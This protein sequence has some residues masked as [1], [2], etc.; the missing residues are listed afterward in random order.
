MFLKQRF[1]RKVKSSSSNRRTSSNNRSS[2][3]DNS[4]LEG[5]Q[6]CVWVHWFFLVC[7]QI[8]LQNKSHFILIDA[9]L[10]HLV[11]KLQDCQSHEIFS[12]WDLNSTVWMLLLHFLYHLTLTRRLLWWFHKFFMMERCELTVVIKV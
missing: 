6:C 9:V 12:K 8:L 11:C 3:C 5:K 2:N 7:V 1:V 4:Y 10:F